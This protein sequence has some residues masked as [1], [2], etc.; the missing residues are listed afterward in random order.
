MGFLRVSRDF[1]KRYRE[2]GLSTEEAM[3]IL[4]VLVHQFHQDQ[5]AFPSHKTLA[6][7]AGSSE[8]TSQ[9]YAKHIE[10]LGLVKRLARGRKSNGT[11]R[12]Y[13]LDFTPLFSKI[14]DLARTAP[15]VEE[16]AE[17]PVNNI[18]GLPDQTGDYL[19]GPLPREY[20]D[21]EGTGAQLAD[22]FYTAMSLNG[23]RVGSRDEARQFVDDLLE[24][25][26]VDYLHEQIGCWWKTSLRDRRKRGEMIAG[27]ADF[28]QWLER[29]SGCVQA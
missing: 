8:K 17:S 16:T 13:A 18:P 25:Y 12:S 15:P 7:Y 4:G 2:L 27:Y 26:D 23:L 21:P 28:R 5:P 29:V 22:Y 9:R 24:E 20:D 14:A 6:G 11:H 19:H 3:W 10:S 1:P